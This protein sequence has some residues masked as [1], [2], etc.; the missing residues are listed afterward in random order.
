M[1]IEELEHSKILDLSGNA[2]VIHVAGKR[3]VVLDVA[4]LGVLRKSIFE[5]AGTAA[6][7][8]ILTGFGFSQGWSMASAIAQNFNTGEISDWQE[9]GFLVSGLQGLF[10][11]AEG[12]A[13]P[14]S[15]KGATLE[16]SYEAEYHLR[17]FGPCES[18]VCWTLCGLMSGYLSRTTG[19]NIY[20]LEEACVGRGDPACR[21]LGKTK[22]KW[23]DQREED[24]L[25]LDECRQL[26]ASAEEPSGPTTSP[27]LGPTQ[28]TVPAGP[29]SRAVKGRSSVSGIVAN[30]SV[31]KEL[32]R[33][34]R[35][36]AK[37]EATV[38]V[39]GES[40]TGKERIARLVHDESARASGPFIAVNCAAIAATLCESEL[41]GHARGAFSGASSHRAGLFES[42]NG[43][44]LLLDEIGELPLEMQTKLLRVLQE[45]EVR[46]VGENQA[47]RINV[48]IIAATNLDL[49]RA[50]EQKTFREDLFY[51]LDIVKLTVPPLRSRR[52]D[53]LPLARILNEE[54]SKKMG[55]TVKPLSDRASEQIVRYRWPGNVRQLQ[56]VMERAVVLSEGAYIELGDL[57]DNVSACA[58]ESFAG[59]ATLHA[60][61]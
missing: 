17:H 51:R 28:P 20:V 14:L 46:R 15:K 40:G 5:F 42:A 36:I 1:R 58:A 2:G 47:R 37:V 34:A 50:V 13:N 21:I 45:R 39:S 27:E 60:V 41:F 10:T 43:G 9:A 56:N 55:R 12:S 4:A 16:S 33:V 3:A 48:R 22:A 49:A 30:S 6:A 52:E 61:E 59:R 57:P 44:T 8:T 7:R 53:I 38:I 32:V 35:R 25:V 19:T 54:C 24:L 29:L 11:P 18:P 26:V 31:M 23:G